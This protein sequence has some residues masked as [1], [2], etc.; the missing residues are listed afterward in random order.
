MPLR[1]GACLKHTR[2]LLS[3]QRIKDETADKKVLQKEVAIQKIKSE[4]TGQSREIELELVG[5]N[6]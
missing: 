2:I 4:E 5:V 1:A 6:L 3:L